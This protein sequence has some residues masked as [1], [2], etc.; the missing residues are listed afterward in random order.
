M[1]GKP[2]I[3]G[4]N[5][6]H[7]VQARASFDENEQAR[8]S[9]LF[10]RPQLLMFPAL[11]QLLRYVESMHPGLVV[12]QAHCLRH[13]T[14]KATGF[15]PHRDTDQQPTRRVLKSVIIS[16]NATLSAI[17]LCGKENFWYDEP[18]CSAEFWAE[19]F[20]ESSV[21]NIGA[22]KVAF[23]LEPKR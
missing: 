18:G 3:Y 16:L 17:R 11:Q 2:V 23:F 22:V 20:H 5:Q 13:Q 15:G 14:E 10:N 4:Y 9:L 19:A 1:P 6:Y 12:V 21:M 7:R 8:N